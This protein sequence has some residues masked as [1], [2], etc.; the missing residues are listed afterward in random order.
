MRVWFTIFIIFLMTFG[1]PTLAFSQATP[2]IPGKFQPSKRAWEFADKELKKMSVEEKV[3]QVIQIGIN[4]RFANQ[5]SDYFKALKRDV[6]DN[7]VGGIILF[8]A[9]IYETVQLVNRMQ[10]NAKV[11]LLIALDAETGVGMRFGDATNF[12]WNMAIAAT[13]N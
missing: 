8:G 9:P 4:A 5:D 3:G 12:P 7:K 6:V 13:G 11:P 10:E 2:T 1:S